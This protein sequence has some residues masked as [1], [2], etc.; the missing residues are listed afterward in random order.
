MA[1]KAFNDND[2]FDNPSARIPVCLCLDVSGSMN[3]IVSGDT[4]FTGQT[5]VI[6]GR[7]YKL[8]EGGKTKL[9]YLKDG[10]KTLYED[11]KNNSNTKYAADV[12]IVTF[13]DDAYVVADFSGVREQPSVYELKTGGMTDMGKGVNLALDLLDAR[14]TEYKEAGREYYQ[15][16][17][18][19]MSDGDANG[20]ETELKVAQKRV[21]D[22]VKKDKLTFIPVGFGKKNDFGKNNELNNF[23]ETEKAVRYDSID[24]VRFFKWIAQSMDEV[25]RS[26]VGDKYKPGEK[27]SGYTYM[28]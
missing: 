20:D 9:E 24:Y 28:D 19:L 4:I 11:L 6:D 14:K 18:F 12:S 15:P 2:L 10:I 23:S 3:E 13:S 25:S 27:P 8:C 5:E 17:L 1:K 21:N 16:W 22:L 7:T 26:N